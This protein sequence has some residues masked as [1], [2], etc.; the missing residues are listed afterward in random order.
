MVKKVFAA[1]LPLIFLIC[2]DVYPFQ[3]EDYQ[4]GKPLDEVAKEL[5]NK[6]KTF[7]FTEDGLMYNERILDEPCAVFL[8][9]TPKSKEL[10]FIFLSWD[11]T[12]LGEEIKGT[13]VEKYG[14][15]TT[16][17][18]NIYIWSGPDKDLKKDISDSIYLNYALGSARLIYFGG[19][20]YD[21]FTEEVRSIEEN[22]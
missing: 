3:Y 18:T 6:R 21:K 1:F 22:K 15:F 17:D 12:S 16:I 19:E 13:L 8:Y 5:D 2:S 7:S 20:Y 9:F 14:D 10:A 11:T 4:W